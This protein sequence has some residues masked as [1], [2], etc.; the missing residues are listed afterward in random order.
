MSARIMCAIVLL[1]EIRG[2][3][4]SLP[5]RK[6]MALIFYTQLSNMVTAVSAALLLIL[7]QPLWVTVVRYLSTCMLV[8]TFLVTTCVLI[9]MGGDP[10]KLL[11]SGNGLYHHVL[12]PVISTASYI[13]AENHVGSEMIWLPVLTTFIY[14]VIML[15]LNGIRKVDGPYPF[16]RVHNQSIS[17]TIL[18]ISALLIAM[19]GIS[20]L[21][22][23]IARV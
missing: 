11:W 1:L 5:N 4:L 10:K 2:L 23:A 16:F 20:I 19:A 3:S 13:L 17:A 7:G 9:P 14:G 12:C 22:W 15:Y 8:M 18:W 6:W 21:V